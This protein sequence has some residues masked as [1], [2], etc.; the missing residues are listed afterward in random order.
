MEMVSAIDRWQRRALPA[1]LPVEP[2]TDI[3]LAIN[4]KTA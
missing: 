4:L 2:S 3:P 1:D